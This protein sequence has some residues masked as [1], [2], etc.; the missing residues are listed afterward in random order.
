MTTLEVLFT[1]ADFA[2]LSQRDLGDTVCVVFDVLRATSSMVTALGNGAAAV[3]PVEEISEALDARRR[4]PDVLLAGERDGV[5]I[6][7]DLTGSIDF[8]LGN[9][10][11]EF[12]PERVKDRTIVMTTTNGTRAL[13][14]C[15]PAKTVLAGSFLNLS[16]TSEFLTHE[17]PLKLLLVCSGTF[18]EA[19]FEDVL[20]TG[21]LCELLWASYG[22]G[23][24]A[25]S[26]RMAHNLF[27]LE[28][29]NLTAAFA[30]SRNGRR[31]LS[32][33][34]LREDVEFCLRRD[35]VPL[36]AELNRQGM[37]VKRD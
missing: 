11:R 12:T 18:E 8:D 34:E 1:P 20:G 16:A 6:R 19:A 31:L 24:V 25:D 9:S 17:R 37:V 10:P 28:Q 22:A 35:S 5:R 4:Q 2:A 13:R 7:A 29:G 3:L 33:P 23:A 30:R 27:L 14:S 26:A 15:G 36:V 32:K 21:A